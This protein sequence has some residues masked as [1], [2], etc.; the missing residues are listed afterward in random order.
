MALF[1]Q[2]FED[3]T[4]RLLD[5]FQALRVVRELDVVEDD[6]LLAVLKEEWYF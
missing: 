5:Q 1:S 4:R 6:V 2:E 3:A